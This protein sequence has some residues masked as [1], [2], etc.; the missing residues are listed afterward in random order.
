MWKAAQ[1]LCCIFILLIHR[2]GKIMTIAFFHLSVGNVLF[3]A[4]LQS[5]FLYIIFPS[6]LYYIF[7]WLPVFILFVT[8]LSLFVDR[9][10]AALWKTTVIVLLIYEIYYH[11]KS[12]VFRGCIFVKVSLSLTSGIWWWP[13]TSHQL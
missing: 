5:S 3:S 10:L 2:I 13:R 8:L 1:V 6:F 12:N 7:L 11:L 9:V 4:L